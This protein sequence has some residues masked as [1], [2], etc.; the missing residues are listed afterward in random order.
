MI[1]KTLINQEGD[2]NKFW[3]IETHDNIFHVTF[4][5]VGSKGRKNSREFPDSRTCQY[6]AER[7]ISKKL[8][9]GYVELIEGQKIPEKVEREYRPMDEQ[10]FW[11]VISSFNWKKISDD[12]AVIR[13]AVKRLV[14][15]TEEDIQEFAEILA[16]KLY[17]L[18]GLEYAMNIGEDAYKGKNEYFSVDYF[19]YVRCCVV[20]N[21]KDYYYHV[22]DNPTDMPKD[23]DFEPLL[24]VPEEALN[25]KKK[26]EGEYIDT[27]FSYETFSNVEGW[28]DRK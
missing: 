27:K 15:M 23:V 17:R 26:T 4:G 9:S 22:L 1:K 19:L 16:E 11:S 7:L 13:P 3:T 18:D 8:Q 25:K 5:K 21:G 6:E 28:Q 20:A 10:E 24:Y 12:D 2:S 14:S